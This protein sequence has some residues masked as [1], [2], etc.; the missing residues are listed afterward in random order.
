[1]ALLVDKTTSIKLENR[2]KE[3]SEYAMT[4][5][6]LL[7]EE[8]TT[9]KDIEMIFFSEDD[10]KSGFIYKKI[11]K[12]IKSGDLKSSFDRYSVNY[13]NDCEDLDSFQRKLNLVYIEKLLDLVI[14]KSVD[15]LDKTYINTYK[16]LLTKMKSKQVIK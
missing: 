14:N 9:I 2:L 11:M 15:T 8:R 13:E 16:H 4:L 6:Y 10:E 1:M 5:Y 12:R 7:E 3:F